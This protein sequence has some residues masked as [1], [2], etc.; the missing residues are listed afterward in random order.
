MRTRLRE[1]I[2]ARP[3]SI[4]LKARL[5]DDDNDADKE[6]ENVEC[7]ECRAII[8]NLSQLYSHL[9]VVHGR[10]KAGFQNSIISLAESSEI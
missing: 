3:R 9:R 5:S 6:T 4:K 7:P 10:T 8:S 2:R 1:Q